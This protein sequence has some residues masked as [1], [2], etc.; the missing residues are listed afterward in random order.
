MASN[1]HRAEILGPNLHQAG[2]DAMG[3][4]QDRAKIQIM[5][6]NDVIL[7]RRPGH[8]VAVSGCH[9][10]YATPVHSVEPCGTERIDPAWR[11]IHIDQQPHART[12]AT[13]RSSARQAA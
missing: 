9:R 7:G 2:L 3:G 5:R 1:G 11:E 6:E 10:A 12:S 4:G 13:S 8:D